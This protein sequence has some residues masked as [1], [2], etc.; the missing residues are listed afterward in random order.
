MKSPDKKQKRVRFCENLIQQEGEQKQ[1]TLFEALKQHRR[2]KSLIQLYGN[3][4]QSEKRDQSESDK[5]LKIQVL[6]IRASKQIHTDFRVGQVLGIFPSSKIAQKPLNFGRAKDCEIRFNSKNQFVSEKYQFR[7]EFQRPHFVIIDMGEEY[8]TLIKAPR[9]GQVKKKILLQKYDY[10]SLGEESDFFV[11][12]LTSDEREHL[13]TYDSHKRVRADAM[14]LKWISSEQRELLNDPRPSKVKSITLKFHDGI[15]A[16]QKFTLGG[17]GVANKDKYLIGKSPQCDIVIPSQTQAQSSLSQVH[18][19]ISYERG[20][21][22][23]E[24]GG[25]T[26][27]GT[28]LYPRNVI[29]MKN[30]KE[31]S[32]IKI[33]GIQ[34][35]YTPRFSMGNSS[36]RKSALIDQK[37]QNTPAGLTICVGGH[38]LM[39]SVV[40]GNIE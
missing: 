4:Y 35:T 9:S 6:D 17:P 33:P 5:H 15:L 37:L 12:E 28:Y 23:I 20:F 26:S 3:P 13:Y 19:V 24:D 27:S 11:V 16:G 7:I 18:A 30:H 40:Q 29:Q 10:I 31:S 2:S 21:W 25:H 1:T 32:K 34:P 38:T 36:A 8:P 39:L 14:D 22:Y